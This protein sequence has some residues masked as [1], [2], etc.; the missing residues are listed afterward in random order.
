MHVIKPTT[1]F[2]IGFNHHSRHHS[3]SIVWHTHTV[4]PAA[5]FQWHL[6]H[7]CRHDDNFLS[8]RSSITRK[9][10]CEIRRQR[11]RRKRKLPLLFDIQTDCQ[12]NE[13]KRQDIDVTNKIKGTLPSNWMEVSSKKSDSHFDDYIVCI[14]AWQTNKVKRDPLITI[15]VN[16]GCLLQQIFCPDFYT[17]VSVERSCISTFVCW[18]TFSKVI[19]QVKPHKKDNI[20]SP[21]SLSKTSVK[22]GNILEEDLIKVTRREETCRAVTHSFCHCILLEKGFVKCHSFLKWKIPCLCQELPFSFWHR[23]HSRLGKRAKTIYSC[24]DVVQET[25]KRDTTLPTKPRRQYRVAEKLQTSI[26]IEV[27]ARDTLDRWWRCSFSSFGFTTSA[28]LSVTAFLFLL[29]VLFL[30]VWTSSSSSFSRSTHFLLL[31]KSCLCVSIL[32]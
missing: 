25:A 9:T 22:R 15:I 18:N 20:T 19:I 6:N 1:L 31:F 2:L 14:Q 13:R 12:V 23:E 28:L 29:F 32:F 5:A 11:R 8:K 27:R 3:L 7:S 4:T 16:F 17:M 26:I 21:F 10:V 24:T 30:F